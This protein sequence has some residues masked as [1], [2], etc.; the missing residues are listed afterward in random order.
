MVQ[1]TTKTGDAVIRAELRVVG[2]A[3]LS[4]SFVRVYLGG[5]AVP[6]CADTTVGVN[7][8]ILIPPKGV[9]H[10]DFP[11]FDY[12]NMRW[13]PQNEQTGPVVRT[14]TH[15]GIDLVNKQL[16]IDFVIHADNPGPTSTWADSAEMGDVPGIMMQAG[17]RA[18]YPPATHYL[19]VGD[20][21][22]LPVMS[23]ILATL[24]S[25]AKGH[26]VIELLD[27]ADQLDLPTSASIKFHW[28]FNA[29][30]QHGSQLFKLVKQLNLPAHDRFA[31]IA[32]ESATVKLVRNYLR[33]ELNW[34]RREWYACPY[35][36]AGCSEGAAI[37][38]R[39]QTTDHME[40]A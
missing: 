11:E 5:D 37:K 14:Y 12:E 33:G 22:A 26:C 3:Y 28:Q 21:S 35:W 8:K 25:S 23:V 38:E 31:Y 19:L 27:R 16:W 15:R 1:A 36:E 18:L 4:P 17:K 29:H 13:Q 39:Y 30:P 2:K 24:P 34:Q 20:A 10:I 40:N 9:R 32:A 6:L 7:N